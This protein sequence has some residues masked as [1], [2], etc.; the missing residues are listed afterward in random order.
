[1]EQTTRGGSSSG[2]RDL[3]GLVLGLGLLL[4][5]LFSLLLSLGLLAEERSG[6]ESRDALVLLGSRALDVGLGVGRAGLL[7]VGG[8]GLS[9]SLGLGLLGGGLLSRLLGGLV[10]GGDGGLSNGG[11]YTW[12]S[13]YAKT[14]M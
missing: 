5:L 9:G 6:S 2:L 8:N 12:M 3:G 10:L 13:I 14:G 11:A 7:G 1:L 4:L